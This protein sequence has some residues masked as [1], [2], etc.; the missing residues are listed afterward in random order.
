MEFSIVGGSAAKRRTACLVVGV[1]EG[2]RLSGPARE[3]DRVSRGH[4]T[5]LAR[6]GDLE[7]RA[8]TTLLLHRVPY[9]TATR[10]LVVGLGKEAKFGESAYRNAI[11]TAAKALRDTGASEA[12]ITL[13]DVPC[14]KRDLA[15]RIEQ[16][17]MGLSESGYRFDH[18]KSKPANGGT[19]LRKAILSL[20]NEDHLPE[21][22]T[23]LRRAEAV[24]AGVSLARDLGNLPGN[25]CTPAYLGDCAKQMAQELNLQCE[26][27]GEKEIRKLGMGSFLAVAQGSRQP[28]RFIVLEHRGGPKGS[29]PVVLVGKGITFDT[30]G[31]SLKPGA[32]MDEMKFDMCGAASVLGAMKA[33]SL[34]KLPMN[35]VGLIAATENMPDGNAI[36]PGDIVR[37]MSGQTVEILNTDAEGR[38]ILCDALTYAERYKPA[39]VVNIATL[40][41]A[42]VISLGHVTTGIFANDDAL[43]GELCAAGQASWDRAWHLPM[44]DDYQDGLKSNFADIPNISGGRA[45]GAIIAA[46][47]LSRFTQSYPWAHLD[48]AG[49]AWKSGA[50]KGATGRPVPLLC[51]FLARRAA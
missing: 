43:A 46:C 48:I 36:K 5:K 29:A 18:L 12:I 16:L 33:V 2:R 17:V 50:D 47:F 23:A 44:F 41:G 6:S 24:A 21:A 32:E 22:R 37:T 14:G 40:T 13:A 19:A 7:G 27:M 3:V 8:G 38:L 1:F 35:V 9:L 30:G 15:F 51:A 10:V 49:T 42:M 31:I 34:M 20:A 4:L 39:A 25:I 28:P 11:S 26:V 45:G